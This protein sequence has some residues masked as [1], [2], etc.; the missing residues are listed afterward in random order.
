MSTGATVLVVGGGGREH[1][2]AWKLAQSKLVERVLVAPGNGGTTNSG[3][4]QQMALDVKD[5]ASVL[6]VCKQNNVELVVVG[7]EDPLADGLADSLINAGVP[8][9]GPQQGAAEIESSKAFSKDFMARHSIPTAAYANFT[10][11]AAAIAYVETC[12][13]R[14]VVKASGLA[15]GKG[16]LMPETVE[17]AKEAVRQ[18]MVDE[19]FGS[20]GSEIV[21]EEFMEGEEASILAFVDG[22][23]VVC[24]PA[25]QDHKRIGE[26]DTGL[27]TGGMGAYCPA[28]AVT[29]ALAQRIEREIV[30]PCV[31]GL[32]KEGR[33]FV[34]C[35]FTGVMLTAKGPRCLEYNCRFGDPETEAVLPLLDSEAGADLYEIMRACARHC[36]DSVTVRFSAAHS[37]TVVMASEG[38]PEAYPKGR[39]ITGTADVA[40]AMVFHAGTKI[41]DGQLVTSGG[42]VLAVTGMGA[43]LQ[44]ALDRAY[45]G[46]S[47][48]HFQGAQ[49]RRDI[50]HRTLNRPA[51]L[52]IGV[53][54]ST[55]GTD[56]QTIID[57]IEVGTCNATIELV[58]ANRSS[59][60][61]L[62]RA[63]KHGLE[64]Q[65]IGA[66][67][68]SREE[69]DTEVT[70][71]F[72]GTNVDLVLLI[73]FMRILSPYFVQQWERKVL[74]VHPS[75]LPLHAGGMDG[76][77]HQAV[78]DAGETETGCTIHWVEEGVDTGLIA[79]QKTV[80]VAPGETAD[81]LKVKV[82]AL[83]GQAFLEAIRAFQDKTLLG[84]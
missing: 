74:N 19:A 78:L 80:A 72:K 20:A 60:G 32:R 62:A 58:V 41:T 46:I 2:I 69:Y 6:A 9:F 26:G 40:E 68:K 50:A 29:A 28:P 66:K 11:Y 70:A 59:A 53:L 43:S 18:M 56:M 54:G 77:V 73:G 65:F 13:H 49:F 16:V 44:E 83:E 22:F 37:A 64:A 48:I 24:C 42:R 21:I 23:N 57:A 55:R 10:D 8:C 17:E 81:S 25:A 36:L 45:S 47:R 4:I 51:P 39:A 38:Y 61:I 63:R 5:H 75:L 14:V 27:N 35:L 12:G 7:P 67:D 76:D 34:G 79:I 52:R 3:K 15:A 71:A 82:Q 84:L 30:Q 31:D 33:P 1:C